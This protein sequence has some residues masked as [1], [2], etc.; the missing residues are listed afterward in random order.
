MPLTSQERKRRYHARQRVIESSPELKFL[1]AVIKW[2]DRLRDEERATGPVG[3]VG[4]MAAE[5]IGKAEMV[6]NDEEG[7]QDFAF[8]HGIL[9]AVKRTPNTLARRMA[10]EA[11]DA[12]MKHME[13]SEDIVK[14]TVS[15][16]AGMSAARKLI[17]DRPK[18]DMDLIS[19]WFVRDI[20]G[21]GV[22]P[23]DLRVNEHWEEGDLV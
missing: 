5:L 22:A 23:D 17:A 20:V 12:A 14:V 16:N 19:D 2:V 18:L 1:H 6:P 13:S 3:K 7:W 9:E 11:M 8:A 10:T 21:E 4:I 15:I